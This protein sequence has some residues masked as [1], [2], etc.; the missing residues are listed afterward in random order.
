MLWSMIYE[1]RYVQ[2]TE[3]IESSCATNNNERISTYMDKNLVE[4]GRLP[5][6]RTDKELVDQLHN[7][8]KKVT[9]DCLPPVAESKE[10]G[11]FGFPYPL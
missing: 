11:P 6:Q 4:D 1:Y 10:K 7:G 2:V 8:N 5:G 9:Q 3:D